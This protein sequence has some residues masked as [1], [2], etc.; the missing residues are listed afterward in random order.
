[1]DR[2][3]KM[4]MNKCTVPAWILTNQRSGSTFLSSL[5][6]STNQ[7]SSTFNEHF[8]EH[9]IGMGNYKEWLPCNA[10]ILKTHYKNVSSQIKKNVI[11]TY[12]PNIKFILLR[13][14]DPVA[15]T[16]SQYFHKGLRVSFIKK[17]QKRKME[18]YENASIPF[19]KQE[20]ISIY[21]E[22]LLFWNNWDDFLEGEDYICISYEN[23]T[24]DPLRTM[25]RIF[26]Y[27][28]MKLPVEWK[29][30]N[31]ILKLENPLKEEY[32]KKLDKIIKEE[33]IR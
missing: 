33:R 11:K 6:N 20:L 23:F 5:L 15:H 31:N 26:G 10:K 21:K 30:E 16:I 14:K 2:G 1:M 25:N 24:E 32:R 29:P 4:K 28:D 27:L 12:H 18:K 7:F 22:T 3:K 8:H 17:N 13:R 19:N 9:Q